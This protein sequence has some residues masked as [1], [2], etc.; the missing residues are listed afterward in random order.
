M[1]L[2]SLGDG[3]LPVDG[4]LHWSETVRSHESFSVEKV[5]ASELRG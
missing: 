4:Q 1:D 3:R 2:N 5:E